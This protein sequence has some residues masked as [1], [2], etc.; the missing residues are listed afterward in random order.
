M[1]QQLS[2]LQLDDKK[3]N[4]S[5]F[6]EVFKQMWVNNGNEISKIY[7]G[8]GALQGESKVGF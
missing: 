6:I 2:S 3:Q 7:A 1:S 5:R 4:M 8:T